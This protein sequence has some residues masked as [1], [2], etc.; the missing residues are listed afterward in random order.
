MTQIMTQLADPPDRCARRLARPYVCRCGYRLW[1]LGL[2]AP[3]R[4]GCPKCRNPQTPREN[5]R[6]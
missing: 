5:E 3:R 1:L 4:I 2:S 6:G